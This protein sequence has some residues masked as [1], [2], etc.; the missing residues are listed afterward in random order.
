MFTQ[1]TLVWWSVAAVAVAFVGLGCGDGGPGGILGKQAAVDPPPP[2]F[3][4][5]P[6]DLTLECDGSDNATI[7]QD[8][9]ASATAVAAAECGQPTVTDDFVGLSDDCVAGVW[10]TPVTWTA[11]DECGQTNTTSATL[12]ILDPNTPV[13]ELVADSDITL[14]CHVDPYVE[15]GA[16][17]SIGCGALLV[18]ATID[19]DAV[20]AN[21]PDTYVVTYDYTDACGNVADQVTRTVTVVD[22]LP[23]EVIMPDWLQVWPPN[24]TYRTFALSDCVQFVDACEGPIDVD[25]VGRILSIYSDE[26]EDTDGVGDGSTVDDIVLLGPTS[27]MV[28]SERQGGSNGR[29]YG[30]EFELTDR[31]GYTVTDTCLLGVPHDQS[32]DVPIDDGPSSGYTVVPD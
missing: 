22:T 3:D 8:W 17:V 20:D 6:A 32:G 31:H 25:A 29:V 15:Q 4:V 16:A 23:P 9:L 10:V 27:F 1:R 7:L 12:T 18:G 11:E 14:E 2:Q 30:V 19:G 5:A 26:P 21:T 28:R 24:H 13:I